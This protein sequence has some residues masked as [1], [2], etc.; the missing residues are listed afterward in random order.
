MLCIYIFLSKH[1]YTYTHAF[2]NN[3]KRIEVINEVVQG[4]VAQDGLGWGHE[5]WKGC[6]P[7]CTKTY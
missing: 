2:N 5:G 7:N 3:Y 6:N 4:R 1:T